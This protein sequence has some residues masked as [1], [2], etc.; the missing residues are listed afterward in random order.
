MVYIGLIKYIKTIFFLNWNRIRHTLLYS[1]IV[2]L[3][4]TF[5]CSY[6]HEIA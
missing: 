1:Q 2:M 5:N 6:M 3:S 4:Y